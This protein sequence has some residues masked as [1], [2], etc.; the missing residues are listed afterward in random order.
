[1]L[2]AQQ[3]NFGLFKKYPEE[4]STKPFKKSVSGIDSQTGKI[5]LINPTPRKHSEVMTEISKDD[6]NK[7]CFCISGVLDKPFSL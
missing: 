2:N 6:F 7:F 4:F 1:M 5:R 3:N